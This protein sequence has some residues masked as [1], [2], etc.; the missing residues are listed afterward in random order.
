MS[1]YSS[2]KAYLRAL[3]DEQ[4][5]AH[6][7]LEKARSLGLM[8]HDYERVETSYGDAKA[9]LFEALEMMTGLTEKELEQVI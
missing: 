3:Y 7:D 6:A 2:S 8:D 1:A 4:V 5:A 9:R